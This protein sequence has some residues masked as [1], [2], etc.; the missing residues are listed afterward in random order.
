MKG[1]LFGTALLLMLPYSLNGQDLQSVQK[2]TSTLPS[3]ARYEIVQSGI[4][5]QWTFKLDRITG[6][7]ERLA[8]T[9]SGNLVWIKTRVLPHPKAVNSAKP[10]YQIVVASQPPYVALLLDTESGATWQLL[11][12]DDGGVWQTIE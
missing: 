1:R 12:R 3:D 4:G 7:V 9:E 11:P 5:S 2:Q 10:H 8:S 6:N